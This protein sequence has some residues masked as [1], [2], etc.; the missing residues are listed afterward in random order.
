[1]VRQRKENRFF[2]DIADEILHCMHEA[3]IHPGYSKMLRTL[4]DEINC[5]KV[6]QKIK[7]ITQE[8][9]KCQRNKHFTNNFGRLNNFLISKEPEETVCSD[10]LGPIQDMY[11]T[12]GKKKYIVTFTDM[13]TRFTN[14]YIV[15]NI[16]SHTIVE[17]LKKFIFN[18]FSPKKLLTDQGKQYTSLNFQVF[19]TKNNIIH[20]VTTTYTPTA[21]SI[22]ERINQ[23]IHNTLK[24]CKG[25]KTFIEAV[26]D[27]EFH[28]NF[29]FNR[30]INTSPMVVYKKTNLFNI[31]IPTAKNYN[32]MHEE[33]IQKKKKDLLHANLKRKQNFIYKIGDY[34]MLRN[35]A[36]RKLD[37]VWNGPYIIIDSKG[38]DNIFQLENETTKLWCSIRN[39]RFLRG[40]RYRDKP[41]K[42]N[43]SEESIKVMLVNKF[44]E[45][46]HSARLRGTKG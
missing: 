15:E 8:C 16:E 23:T 11:Y 3:L 6:C 19:C 24:I 31:K 32:Q 41:T 4:K 33:M 22:A 40:V 37:P 12:K 28:C 20:K 30:S 2:P 36:L 39:M 35:N 44:L 29:T 17:S 45:D 34:V 10:I 42:N 26:K 7:K 25:E 9:L 14:F 21:N 46:R 43:L 1:M 5:E 27:A 38:S 13:F 18:N